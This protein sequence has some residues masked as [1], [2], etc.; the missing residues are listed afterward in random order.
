MLFWPLVICYLVYGIVKVPGTLW[1]G[2]RQQTAAG[3]AQCLTDS[4]SLEADFYAAA[5]M[6]LISGMLLFGYLFKA[7]S[8]NMMHALP[9]TRTELFFTNVIS[10]FFFMFVPQILV[11][12][13]TMLVSLSHRITQ[14]QYIGIWLLSVMGVSFF[15]YADGFC[16]VWA[17]FAG[18]AAGV[19]VAWFTAA[20]LCPKF[21]KAWANFSKACANSGASI[22]MLIV[23]ISK[24]PFLK[25]PHR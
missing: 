25:W 21:S 2:I 24:T 3:Y 11:F 5:A 16:G 14:V 22:V 13:V 4:L 15:L 8:A 17:A 9:V 7:E 1:M 12:L 6:A 23:F 20:V 10:G 19:C 18:T